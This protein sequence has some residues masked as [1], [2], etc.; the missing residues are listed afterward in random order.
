MQKIYIQ[1]YGCQMNEYD[2]ERLLDSMKQAHNMES[3]SIPEEADLL[4][5]NTCSIREKAQEKTFS[6]LGRWR[7]FKEKNK[8]SLIAVI[9][10]V[11][12]Q[13]GKDIIKRAPFVDIVLG[14]QTLH[15][16]P[17][18]YEK[19]RNQSK[20]IVDV[21]F[22][23]IEKFDQLPI[24]DTNSISS[25]VSIME[26]CSKYCSYCIVPYTRGE[27]ISRPFEDIIIEV[28]QLIDQ[29]VKEITLLGQNV[30]DYYGKMPNG[31]TADLA[32]LI[33][34][35]AAFDEIE[36]I[37]F[38]TSHPTAFSQNLIDCY[39]EEPKLAAHLH[40][41]V[42]SGSN[43]ILKQMKRD[44]S[45]ELYKEKIAKIRLARPNITISS[46]FIVGFP[47]E[48]SSHF[49]QTL[50]LV[51]EIEFDKSY[52]FIYSQRPGTPAADIID[53]IPLE[54]K[55]LRLKLLQD[56]LNHQTQTISRQ[57]LSTTQNVLVLDYS[58]K[59][60]SQ[61]TGRTENNRVV[62]F[63]APTNLIG[64]MQSINITD[65]YQNSLQGEII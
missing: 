5:V 49:E 24:R 62:N 64:T 11:A 26:G 41:P 25:S 22:P 29:G 52:S 50:N 39:R 60:D 43:E 55:K 46:D 12:S 23:E 40:L 63:K 20:S 59:S 48:T 3:T 28:K 42:Q 54:E 56:L 44:Y 2:S 47:G 36:R 18:I 34:Y 37:R 4:V 9:G 53:N 61:L 58:K 10:C 65:V 32:L 45:I 1:T 6:E 30:N 33:H 35:I 51:K 15:K 17:E 14:P 38:T 31:H 57:M 13:E 21:S 16:M 27:E 8:H 19:V 7:K